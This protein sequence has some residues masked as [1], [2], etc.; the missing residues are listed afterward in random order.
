MGRKERREEAKRIAREWEPPKYGPKKDDEVSC[1]AFAM[2]NL[3]LIPDK[4]ILDFLNYMSTLDGF[5]GLY[6]YPP[7]GT[8]I[9]FDTENNA[10]GG[11]NIL[12]TY[13]GIEFEFGKNIVE[14]FINKKYFKGEK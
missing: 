13:P 12:R 3:P 1:Y 9:I 4:R 14:I 6:P 7:H 11:R 8:L 5:Q 2:P 10:K